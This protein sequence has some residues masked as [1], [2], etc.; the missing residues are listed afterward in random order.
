LQLSMYF[1][2]KLNCSLYSNHIYL[3]FLHLLS[4]YI[5]IYLLHH[6]R[7]KSAM[8]SGLKFNLFDAENFSV[9]F[10]LA[11]YRAICLQLW[12]EKTLQIFLFVIAVYSPLY[13]WTESVC[14][15]YYVRSFC[16]TSWHFDI[17]NSLWKVTRRLWLPSWRSVDIG[18]NWMLINYK[19]LSSENCII[20]I[21]ILYS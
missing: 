16:F 1:S 4:S 9:C 3:Y 7:W 10:L 6:I 5:Y 8:F 15:H 14:L 19:T 12:L 17:E 21:N 13:F 18:K 11:I 20:V 2:W